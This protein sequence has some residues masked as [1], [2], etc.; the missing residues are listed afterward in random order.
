MALTDNN[1]R[2]ALH[3]AAAINDSGDIYRILEEL[4]ADVN[5]EDDVST[6][7]NLKSLLTQY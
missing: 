5:K 4:G 2:T 6:T 3:Y 1:E 7:Y